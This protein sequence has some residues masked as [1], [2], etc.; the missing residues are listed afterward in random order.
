METVDPRP[1]I[2]LAQNSY[3]GL[4]GFIPGSRGSLMLDVVFLAMFAVVPLLIA[5][6]YLVKVRHRY[7]L[8][9]RLQ[10]AMAI[11]LLVAVVLFELDIRINGW[12]ARAEPSPYFDALNKW[13]CPAGI[14]LIVHLSFAVPTLVLWIYVVAAALRKFSKPPMPGTHSQR[15]AWTGWLAAGGMILTAVTGWLFYWLAFVAR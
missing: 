12:E 4:S 3:G 10:L 9:K 15:H 14:S 7:G 13:S 6:I 8:H 11:V 2:L 1:M 5:S